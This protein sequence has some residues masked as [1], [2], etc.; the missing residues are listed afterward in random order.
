MGSSSSARRTRRRARPRS[1]RRRTRGPGSAPGGLISRK[2]NCEKCETTVNADP[3]A[4]PQRPPIPHACT[5]SDPPSPSSTPSCSRSITCGR[6]EKQFW[7]RQRSGERWRE[8]SRFCL[9]S[10][11]HLA[12]VVVRWILLPLLGGLQDLVEDL[13]DVRAVAGGDEEER[14]IPLGGKVEGLGGHLGVAEQNVD[15][16]QPLVSQLRKKKNSFR[17]PTL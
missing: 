4:T 16:C 17:S 2:K 9:F 11:S 12:V 3:K 6:K 8:K 14:E 13:D 5:A 15:A 7:G 10:P 1:R